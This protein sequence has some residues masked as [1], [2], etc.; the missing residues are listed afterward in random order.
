MVSILIHKKHRYIVFVHPQNHR[1]K[2]VD[3]LS[4]VCS[5]KNHISICKIQK[6]FKHNKI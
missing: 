6:N 1:Q 5:R 3:N 2:N 4:N